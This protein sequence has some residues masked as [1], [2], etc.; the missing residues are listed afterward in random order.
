MTDTNIQYYIT[1]SFIAYAFEKLAMT[2]VI[3]KHFQPSLMF[4]S[5][6]GA[7]RSGGAHFA[8]SIVGLG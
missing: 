7:D 8:S 5:K 2:F 4:S 3:G 1:F 6:S